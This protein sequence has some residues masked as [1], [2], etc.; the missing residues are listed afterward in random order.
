MLQ[1]LSQLA[2]R[3]LGA[4]PQRFVAPAA[5]PPPDLD[6]AGQEP[7]HFDRL[8]RVALTDG[9][10][11]TLFEDFASHCASERGH[12]ETGWILLGERRESESIVLATL[13]A[14]AHRDAGAAHVRFDSAAQMVGSR[15]LRRFDRKLC[16]LGVVHTHP[17][18]MRHPSAGDF[19]GDSLWVHQLRGREGLFGIGTVEKDAL[20]PPWLVERA[21]PHVHRQGKLRFTWF[22]LAAGDRRYRKIPVEFTIGPDLGRPAHQAWNTIERHARAIERIC[23]Q[24]TRVVLEAGGK[25][26]ADLK[27]IV[28]LAEP[29]DA[30]EIELVK[31]QVVFIVRQGG[32]QHLVDPRESAIERGLYLIL[33]ELAAR[34]TSESST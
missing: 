15:L 23:R 30:V 29:G 21:R 27:L 2:H 3:L 5:L 13:P 11:R 4:L 18:S 34:G 7:L 6:E 8:R 32:E 33:A 26:G 10:G 28:P 16:V 12:E 24:Q 25:S 17:G 19:R 1:G 14:G 9:V 22:A 31:D 20:Q